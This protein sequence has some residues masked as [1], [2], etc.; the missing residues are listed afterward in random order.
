ML[1]ILP[2]EDIVMFQSADADNYFPMLRSTSV[3]NRAFCQRH[4]IR[5]TVL[6]GILRGYHPWHAAYNRILLLDRMIALGFRGWFMHVDSDAYVAE[7]GFDIR[8]Y[9]ASL[10]ETSFVFAAGARAEP[11]DVN[12]GVFLANCAH[13]DTI[14]VSRLWLEILQT[15]GPDRLRDSPQ[16]YANGLPGDQALLH[17][18]LR[19]DPALTQAIWREHPS[20]F[21]GPRASFIR[22]VMRSAERD[23][24]QR[25][26]RIVLDV[27][28]AKAEQELPPENPVE[29][30]CNLARRA[31]LP[32]PRK[33]DG[34]REMV[35][36]PTQLEQLLRRCLRQ[37]QKRPPA[38]SAEPPA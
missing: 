36:D 3:P 22:Q 5:Y 27:E 29:F 32:L 38:D 11:W 35:E 4:G 18:V 15:I 20:F 19:R 16:W 34:I 28:R 13:P 17:A 2:N 31:G 8:A 33:V 9:L 1:Q 12:D 30:Y 26:D 7:T 24:H 21:N 25:L 23:P 6:Y 37:L 10:G 14:E